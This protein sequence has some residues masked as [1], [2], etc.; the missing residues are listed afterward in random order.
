MS[1]PE[2]NFRSLLVVGSAVLAAALL[3]PAASLAGPPATKPPG[4]GPHNQPASARGIV[5]SASAKVVVVK[6]LDGTTVRIPVGQSTHVF[7]DGKRA[8][9]GDV[10]AGLVAIASW[11]GDQATGRLQIFDASA[12]VAVVQ[13]TTSRRVVAT[14]PSGTNAT[15]RVT[16]KTRVL[17]DGKPA[18]LH[19]VKPGFLLVLRSGASTSKPAVELRFLRPS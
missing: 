10:H 19:A 12:T 11:K 4:K 13:S 8:T 9:L 6:E 5:Q 16:P 3:L 18:Q 2:R 17:V 15:I 7:L 1:T 14:M